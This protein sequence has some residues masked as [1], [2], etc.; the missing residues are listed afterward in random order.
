MFNSLYGL[1]EVLKKYIE[2]VHFIKSNWLNLKKNQL[3]RHENNFEKLIL[4]Q[5]HQELNL[6]LGESQLS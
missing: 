1:I 5:P 2:I 6:G 4:P 3:I